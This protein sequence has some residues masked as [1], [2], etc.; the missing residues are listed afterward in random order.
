MEIFA[1]LLLTFYFPSRPRA[2]GHFSSGQIYLILNRLSTFFLFFRKMPFSASK[3]AFFYSAGH[4]KAHIYN[5]NISAYRAKGKSVTKMQIIAKAVLTFLGLSALAN[6]CANLTR[7][8]SLIWMQTRDA[9]ILLVVLFSLFVI[10]LLIAI[11]YW[12]IIKNDWLVCKIAGS[13]EKLDLENE[14]LWLAGSFRMVA[15]LYGLILLSGSITTILNILALPFYLR[16]LVSE[17]FTFRTF[18][19][20]LDFTPHQWSSMIYNFFKAILAVY[21]LYGW[22]QFI[23][24]QLNLSKSESS[25]DKIICRR[26]LKNE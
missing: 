5:K 8:P 1:F 10:I 11:V 20:S 15:V 4:R 23:R 3:T 9:S 19:K 16:P 2:T 13:G 25:L 6:F 24:L 18:P 26:N 14:T 21:L 7:L 17:T 22:P 12:L